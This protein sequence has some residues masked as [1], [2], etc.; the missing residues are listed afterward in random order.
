MV[1]AASSGMWLERKEEMVS[2][3]LAN[4]Q[5]LEVLPVLQYWQALLVPSWHSPHCL[6][7]HGRSKGQESAGMVSQWRML[8]VRDDSMQ[9]GP[10]SEAPVETKCSRFAKQAY[11]LF[12]KV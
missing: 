11:E 2:R 4:A 8:L 9:G 6:Q 12:L 7:P 3:M 10:S 5:A 1:R